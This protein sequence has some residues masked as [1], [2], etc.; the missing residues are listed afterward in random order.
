MKKIVSLLVLQIIFYFV[1]DS[2]GQ[3]KYHEQWPQFRGPFSSGI[4]DSAD[5]PVNWNIKSGENI[6]WKTSIPGLGH[7]CPTIWNEK[8]FI[9]TAISGSGQDSLKV[10]LYGDIDD[11]KDNSIHEFR[12]YCINKYTGKIIWERLAHKGVP[13]TR[14]HT[15]SSHA[16]STPATNGKFVV[17]F[18]GSDG[19]YCYNMDGDL[20]WQ[21]DFEKMNY[22]PYTDPE[23]EWGFASSPIIHEDKII[24]Q[25]DF[26]G[27][28]FIA[29]LDVTTAKEIWK[30][31]RDEISTW[32]TPNF[33]NKDSH[34]QI[35]VNGWKHMG[36]YD[37]DSGEEIWKLSNGGD[38]PVPTPIF[39]HGL[40]YI[41]NAHGRYSP[42]FAIRPGAKGDITLEKESTSSEHIKWSIKRG[43]AYMPT[44][45][46]YGDYLYNLRMNGVLSCYH[47]KSGKLE[48]K[49]KIPGA[50]GGITASGIC[51]DGKLYYC[52]EQGEVFIVK[53]GPEFNVLGQNSMEDLI[54]ATPAISENT[55]FFRTQKFLMAISKE[56]YIN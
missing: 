40:I 53:T 2:F 19:L 20:M 7:S 27:E 33:Y 45:V 29:S 8:L 18:F 21:K 39:A 49:N 54:M 24:I 48:Y 6:R 26:L 13:S 43:G 23:A 46:I 52:T 10:G 36:A 50:N 12:L 56:E 28:G 4:L 9:T 1:C 34:R 37:F 17:A 25:C 14:R 38:A 35:V 11:V 41:H 47:A 16:N 51:S 32:S 44:I 22:G 15:K 55:L 30:T 3:T 42:I 31:P 5:L